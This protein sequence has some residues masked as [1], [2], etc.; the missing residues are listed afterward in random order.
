V[1]GSY[2][3][4]FVIDKAHLSPLALGV[5]LTVYSLSGMIISTSFGHWFDRTP[6]PIPL[7]LALVMTISG[8][9]LLSVTTNLYLLLLIAG[10]PLGTSLAVFPQLFALAKGRLDR[11]GAETAE[12]GTAMMRATWSIAWAV[13]PALGALMISL[14]DFQGVFLTAAMCVVTATV[15]VAVARVDALRPAKT[16]R[17][18]EKALSGRVGSWQVVRDVI[19]RAIFT[20]VKDL[21]GKPRRYIDAYSASAKPIQWKYS[22]PSRRIRSSV[23]SATCG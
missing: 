7:L 2:L 16:P 15:I 18:E 10:L 9:A 4:L 6:S 8:Y 23:V 20:S 5:F 1:G 19:A 11:V 3:T 14:F 13:G 12:R 17:N 21:A 22:D